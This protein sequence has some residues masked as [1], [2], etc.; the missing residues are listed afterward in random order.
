MARMKVAAL[1]VVM[2]VGLPMAVLAGKGS[3]GLQLYVDHQF[4][5]AIEQCKGGKDITS[6]LV[7]ALSH[8]ERYNIY[9]DKVDKEQAGIY[10]KLL[11]VDVNMDNVDSIT[12]FLEIAGNPNGNKEA[13]DLLKIAFKNSKATTDHI[14]KMAEFLDPAKGV[15]VNKMALSAIEKKLSPVRDYVVKGGTMPEEM[16]K[17]FVNKA[18]LQ[19]MIACLGNEKTASAAKSCLVEIEEP[20]LVLLEQQEMTKSVSDTIV[21]VK[22]AIEKRQKKH[23]DSTWFSAYSK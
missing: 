4:D 7:L 12:K 10:L 6:K 9:K 13:A 1:V 19:P 3:D 11:E 17:L 8:T 22:K 5:Q 23:P 15:E 14:M 16:Q 2:A 18:L 20:V 21:A